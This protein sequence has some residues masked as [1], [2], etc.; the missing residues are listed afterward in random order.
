MAGFKNQELPKERWRLYDHAANVLVEYWD[1][2][3]HLRKH[4]GDSDFLD[5]GDKKKLLRRLAYRMQSQQSGLHGNYIDEDALCRL[6][7]DYFVERYE[8]P[9]HEAK[10]LAKSMIEQFHQRNFIL[11]RYGQ[12][13]YGFVHRTFLE[14]FC[15]QAIVGKFQ[16][17]DPEWRGR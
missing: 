17:R 11:G 14:F 6:F 1:A 16:K 5:T 13:V 4:H 15:A 12:R 3:R 10:A 2:D 8:H 7:E 9:K